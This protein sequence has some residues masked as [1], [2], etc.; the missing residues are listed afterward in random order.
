M[1]KKRK[2]TL[3]KIEDINIT[4]DTSCMHPIL[5]DNTLLCIHGGKVNLKAKNAKR[6]K[7]DNIPIMLHNEI[8]GASISGCVNPPIA[9]GPC[10]KVALVFAHTYSN[11]KVNHKHSVLQMGLIGVSNKG[12]PILAI[13]KQNKIKFA[14]TKIK[15]NPLAKIKWDKIKWEGIESKEEAKMLLYLENEN[16][17]GKVSDKE[18]HLYKY[19][20]IWPKDT[21]KPRSSDYI[22]E[23]GKITLNIKQR[24]IEIK[25]TLNRGYNSVSIETK[26]KFIRYDLDGKPH[27]EKTLKKLINTPHK[28]EYTKHINPQDPTKY[29]MSKGIVEPISHKDLDIVENYL[30]RQK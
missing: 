27:Y 26:D 2:I 7:S 10:T 22:C 28:V 14:L 18:V 15:A 23:N 6:I 13:P 16:K 11:H 9:G 5:E 29:R 24:A 8:Q 3:P 1:A 21:L 30:K 4:P 17:K 20:G 25:N 19:N 12:Y